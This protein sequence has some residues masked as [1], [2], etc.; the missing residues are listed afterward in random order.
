MRVLVTGGTWFVGCHTVAALVDQ[1]YQVR[2]D[3]LRHPLASAR[4]P[5]G[6]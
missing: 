3:G 1:G 6:R 2:P 4:S 5:P